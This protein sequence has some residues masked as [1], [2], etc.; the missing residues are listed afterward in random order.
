MLKG[1]PNTEAKNAIDIKACRIDST[2]T[3]ETFDEMYVKGGI[4]ITA[5]SAVKSDI[6]VKIFRFSLVTKFTFSMQ[7]LYKVEPKWKPFNFILII[8]DTIPEMD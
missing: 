5:T 6:L 7:N 1:M 3:F 8:T 2:L 4:T